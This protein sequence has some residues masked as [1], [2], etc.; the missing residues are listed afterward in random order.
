M[1]L[2]IHLSEHLSE[3]FIDYFIIDINNIKYHR[4]LFIPYLFL[5][6]SL[7]VPYF[8]I[9]LKNVLLAK[10]TYYPTE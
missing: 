10:N 7:F 6:C 5:I 9:S 8:N 3:H 2:W 4:S 1:N